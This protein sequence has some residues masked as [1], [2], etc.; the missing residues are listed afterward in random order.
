M[1]TFLIPA[2]NEEK[3]IGNCI[4]VLSKE[5]P[6][7][8]YIVVFDGNDRTPDVVSR[9][10]NVKLIRFGNRVGKGRAII[11]GLKKVSENDIVIII[12]ADMP[13]D[14]SDIR[15]AE[16]AFGNNDMLIVQRIYEQAPGSRLFL[17]NSYMALAKLLFPLLRPLP[18]WQ[19]GFKLLKT[20]SV[21]IV[22]K[23]LVL[24]DFLFD[25]NLVY[26]FLKHNMKVAVL[27]VKWKHEEKESKVSGQILKVILLFLLSLLKMRAYYSPLRIWLYSKSFLV[28]QSRIQKFLR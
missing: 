20:S 16:K 14:A 4:S 6:D 11:E 15:R 5:F 1:S 7:S 12:D 21:I 23:E 17:H 13:V 25:T 18:D 28:V 10:S 27:P 3:R 2:Y 22:S 19:G 8:S 24:N 9:Y 26:S